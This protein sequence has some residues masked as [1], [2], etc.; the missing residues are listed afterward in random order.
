MTTVLPHKDRRDWLWNKCKACSESIFKQALERNLYICPFCNYYF[1]MP[2]ESRLH[3]LFDS[4]PS[5]DLYPPSAPKSLLKSLDLAELVSQTV[6]PELLSI[7]SE[8]LLRSTRQLI[9]AGEGEISGYPV[10]LTVI[11]PYAVSQRVHFV[12]LLVAIRTALQRELPLITVYPSDALPK[13]RQPDQPIESELSFAETTYLTIEMDR[14]S[15]VPLS[16]ITVLTEANVGTAL[17]TKFPLGDL[18]LAERVEVVQG[19]SSPQP[20]NQ[21]QPDV[22]VDCYVQRQELPTMLS[23]L[24]GFFANK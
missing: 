22:F 8:P 1:P 23:K 21:P 18:V 16:Q 17:S 7:G 5:T 10:I 11:H 3:H 15:Q 9:V 14:V 24:L 6:F 20:P 13:L 4:E 12:A 2:A 19:K